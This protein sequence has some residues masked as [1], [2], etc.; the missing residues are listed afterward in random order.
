MTTRSWTFPAANDAPRQARHAAR[1]YAA[2]HG[3][4][5][6]T[7]DTIALCVG[8]AA[9]NVVMHAYRNH[10]A[11]GELELQARAADGYL[12]FY[13]RDQGEGMSPRVDSPGLGLGLAL[14]S[15]SAASTEIRAPKGGGTEVV[16][17]FDL[18][19]SGAALN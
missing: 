15:Q 16:M 17:R 9:T 1:D 8:E 18:A 7:L 6:D 12:C 4:D 3:A 10:S 5:A 14:I 19:L 2:Q 11:P 13:V